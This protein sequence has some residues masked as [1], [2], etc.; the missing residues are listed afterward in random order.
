MPSGQETDHAYST[1]PA[2]C[3][4]PQSPHTLL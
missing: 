3:T 1:T 2:A 4:G